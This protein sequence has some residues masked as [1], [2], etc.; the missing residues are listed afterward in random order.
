[1][2][3][4]CVEKEFCVLVHAQTD[5]KKTVQR[6]FM[7]KFF[8]KSSTTMQILTWQKNSKTKAVCAASCLGGAR[9]PT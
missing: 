9:V 2:V 6:V 3:F 7:R 8:K 5:S 1:M 4:S